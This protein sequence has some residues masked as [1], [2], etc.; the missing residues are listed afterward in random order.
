MNTEIQFVQLQKS[1]A[2]NDYVLEKLKTLEE[3]YNWITN[4][5]VFLKEE[6]HDHEENFV[7]EIRLS[8]PGPQLF[9]KSHDT[10]FNTAVNN[11]IQ[12]LNNQL[13]KKKEKMQAR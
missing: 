12:E 3:K 1:D 5:A 9:A 13:T 2:L 8:V 10:N 4:A 7:C 6:K 11:V